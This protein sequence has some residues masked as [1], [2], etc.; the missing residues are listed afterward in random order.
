MEN[1][2]KHRTVGKF[3]NKHLI[4][5]EII[6]RKRDGEI[7]S[8]DEIRTFT[9]GAAHGEVT[10]EQIAALCMAIW[11]QGLNTDEQ[12]HLT[13]AIRD[14]GTVLEW[15]DLPGPVLD[16]HST[17]G[18]GDMISFAV[19][20]IVAACGGYVPMISGRGLGHTGGTLDKLES[21]PGINVLPDT[22]TF[23][24]WV[25][26]R[27]LAIVGQTKDL[28]PADRHFYAVRDSTATVAS[29]PL[30]VAS[31]L[32]KKL[33]EGLDG[34]VMDIKVGNGAFMP[35]IEA[36]RR[37]AREL[38]DVASAAALPCTAILTDMHIPLSWS[39]GNG[40][41]LLE[42]ME[43]LG[44]EKRNPRFDE[45]A[46]AVA[47]E[48]LRIGRLADDEQAAQ[49]MVDR[50]LNDGSAAET[51]ARMVSGQGG[52][53]VAFERLAGTLRPAS[54]TRAVHPAESGTVTA[55][56]LRQ[57][58]LAVVSLGGGRRRMSDDI[59]HSVGLAKLAGFGDEVGPDR[60]LAIVHAADYSTCAHAA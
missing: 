56:S 25:R 33:C 39:A 48:M 19:G 30:I 34:L 15:P 32:G 42:V 59:D 57:L 60:P 10:H 7:L 9:L 24:R 37:L 38:C 43:Y 58:G 49:K 14:S 3:D 53:S 55:V 51:F 6:G 31:I 23:T 29:E 17:G 21:F 22:D 40:L 52:P 20:P 5:E 8:E 2:A 13:L 41:E 45:V 47:A 4:P 35:E 11:F 27:G 28:A 26:E 16:K 46:R 44:G 36:G 12:A 54:I 18:V 50:A 1:P